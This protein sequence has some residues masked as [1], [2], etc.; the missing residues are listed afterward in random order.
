MIAKYGSQDPAKLVFGDWDSTFDESVSEHRFPDSV[1]IAV[2][3]A[4]KD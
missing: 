3:V 2:D 1:I 4:D